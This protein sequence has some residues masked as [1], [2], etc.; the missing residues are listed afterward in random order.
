M[1]TVAL[2]VVAVIATGISIWSLMQ[3][4]SPLLT[5]GSI[6]ELS[7]NPPPDAPL[8]NR[9][10]RELAISTDGRRIVYLAIS[11]GI[12]QL[13]LRSLGDQEAK[14]IPGTEGA[15]PSPFF[16]PDG[17]SIA[18]TAA[19][20]LKRVGVTGGGPVTL[21]NTQASF[22]FSSG[23]WGPEDTIVF[24]DSSDSGVALYRISASGGEAEPLAIPDPDKGESAFEYPQILPGGETVLFQNGLAGD[25][26]SWVVSLETGERK[27]VLEGTRA[28][29]YAPTGHLV[30]ETPLT[31]TLMAVSFDL[32]KLEVTGDPGP[33]LEGVRHHAIDY[34]TVDYQFSQNGTLVYIPRQT[35]AEHELVW[36]DRQGTESP[37][38]KERGNYIGPRISPDGKQV[39][40]TIL[41]TPRSVWIYDLEGDSFR[42]LTFEGN[43][44]V[45]TWSPDGKWI[46]YG[47][48]NEEGR[49]ALYR[50]V[51][52]GSGTPQKLTDEN[53]RNPMSNSWSP[54]GVLAFTQGDTEGN[55]TW[56]LPMD[57]DGSPQLLIPGG[58]FAKF[59]PDGRWVA[60]GRSE[61][62]QFQ[63]Y[64]S[65]Y[66]EPEVQ[67]QVSGEEG[68]AE[69]VW[70]PDGTELF[71]RSGNQMM[72]VSI[73]T[74][75]TFKAGRPRVLFEGLYLSTNISPGY[76]YYDISSD[77]QRFL[78]IKA[79]E[80]STGQIN[81]VLNWF[82][83]L[84]RLVPTD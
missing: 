34:A 3:P 55:S 71:Y 39:A 48:T 70:S 11:E 21:G 5:A 83:E 74:E 4:T 63:V 72:V 54:E 10:G 24:T 8:T 7:I 36:V 53:P 26:D 15:S 28:A 16:S 84:K 81:V 58:R 46:V 57:G 77:G 44:A 82:E 76:Q 17:E 37:I 40:L 49:R 30:Y 25:S 45:P 35:S 9:P 14:P 78:M 64:V 43:N 12:R 29:R 13:F 52:D 80:G 60:Y 56:I 65:P 41:G 59:S 33:M 50:Q 2:V 42:R 61:R 79:V 19:G 75:P 62:G 47:S 68:G 73:Q 6:T 22:G 20:E 69:A 31:G 23:S 27:M 66:S 1:M 38:T 32:E 67:W 18:F 51:A